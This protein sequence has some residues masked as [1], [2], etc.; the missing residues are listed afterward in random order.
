M[1]AASR[2]QIKFA[3]RK[4]LNPRLRF[5]VA[6]EPRG[7]HLHRLLPRIASASSACRVHQQVTEPPRPTAVRQP[8]PQKPHFITPP[9]RQFEKRLVKRF[10]L[11][12]TKRS[13]Q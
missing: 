2:T 7:P 4:S 3:Q 12:S 5:P 10:H 8:Q 13:N 9:H 6:R 11:A 1:A